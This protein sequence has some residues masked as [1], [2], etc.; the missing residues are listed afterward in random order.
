MKKL[1]FEFCQNTI[2]IMNN[3]KH[4]LG[5]SSEAEVIKKSLSLL[6]VISEL[7]KT[8]EVI[9][10]AGNIESKIIIQPTA[11]RANLKVVQ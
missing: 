5:V 8:G 1:S 11:Q 4:S 3:L 10:K 2:D 7:T 9:Y 6:S